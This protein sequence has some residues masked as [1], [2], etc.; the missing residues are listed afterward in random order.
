MYRDVIET[1]IQLWPDAEEWWKGDANLIHADR[2]LDP[3]KF[4]MSD[5]LIW[6]N[7]SIDVKSLVMVTKASDFLKTVRY[8]LPKHTAYFKEHYI[9]HDFMSSE[10]RQLCQ[11][12]E[13]IQAGIVSAGYLLDSH[14]APTFEYLRRN[15]PEDYVICSNNT[16]I[17]NYNY[18][19]EYLRIKGKEEDFGWEKWE[20]DGEMQWEFLPEPDMFASKDMPL[21]DFDIVD[22][23]EKISHRTSAVNFSI[24]AACI[25][26]NYMNYMNFREEILL[27]KSFDWESNEAPKVT[28]EDLKPLEEHPSQNEVF[29]LNRWDEIVYRKKKYDHGAKAPWIRKDDLPEPS[30]EMKPLRFMQ[31]DCPLPDKAM[32]RAL[33]TLHKHG[34][35][36]YY[37]GKTLEK[38]KESA[39]YLERYINSRDEVLSYYQRRTQITSDEDLVSA[40]QF[41]K[42]TRKFF[43]WD[44]RETNL[45]IADQTLVKDTL[46]QKVEL[47]DLN[48]IKDPMIAVEKFSDPLKKLGLKI[49]P[50]KEETH[51]LPPMTGLLG[52]P[53]YEHLMPY[54]DSTTLKAFESAAADRPL[55]ESNFDYIMGDIGIEVKAQ[56][57]KPEAPSN[58]KVEVLEDRSE[59]DA[60]A[61]G[62]ELKDLRKQCDDVSF[63]NYL[64]ALG[65][66]GQ[67]DLATIGAVKSGK[68]IET[69]EEWDA[70]NELIKAGKTPPRSKT[71][72][73]PKAAVNAANKFINATPW[74][75]P[76]HGFRKL[77][78]SEAMSKAIEA[79][80][81]TAMNISGFHEDITKARK[82]F[83]SDANESP[84]SL[85]KIFL[86]HLKKIETVAIG[87]KVEFNVQDYVKMAKEKVGY[88]Q[89][90]SG[91]KY[92]TTHVA[93][94]FA[95]GEK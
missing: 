58:V 50:I 72:I 57:L 86:D 67:C 76:S 3:K 88:K 8:N 56:Q 47:P 69:D 66:V 22:F 19:F 43:V 15:Y 48:S 37:K 24:E 87:Q 1:E 36:I 74:L 95:L 12:S 64:E 53:K 40:V 5:G 59:M 61:K 18:W 78:E 84:E 38:W 46:A 30:E 82:D 91:V 28:P 31:D 42:N 34:L 20:E 85:D 23:A 83:V 92:D 68:T 80:F 71:S 65:G 89:P 2:L 39:K 44:T 52:L 81:R 33:R 35:S 17:Q 51:S 90:L 26:V 45:F 73:T 70:K 62:V 27:S 13:Q 55:L 49:V 4:Y 10:N 14:L 21:D 75:E 25:I 54:F 77:S 7:G 63:K 93:I 79:A 32:Q 94:A 41:L 29:L 16:V 6:E 11:E 9:V 60:H